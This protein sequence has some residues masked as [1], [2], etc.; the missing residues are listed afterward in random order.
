MAG[1]GLVI[2]AT[3]TAVIASSSSG[4]QLTEDQLRIGA[5][6]T[7][8]DLGLGTNNPWPGLF[9]A[10]P[11]T[12]RHIAEVYFAADMWP[13]KMIY[14]GDDE[15]FNLALDRCGNEYLAYIAESTHSTAEFTYDEMIPDRTTWQD[16]DRRV[17]CLA[18]K[19]TDQYLD[20]APVNYSIKGTQQ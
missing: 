16:G 6:L 18:Y 13:Q 11:C 3:A 10:V 15:T 14:P 12:E 5:C 4:R 9:I 20:G 7:G 8:S 17:V 2:L 19:V 1:T